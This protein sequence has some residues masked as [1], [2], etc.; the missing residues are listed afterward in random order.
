M[1][2]Q[3]HDSYMAAHVSEALAQDPRVGELGIRVEI[4]GGVVMVKGVVQT[5]ERREAIE[6]VIRELLPDKEIHNRVV[7]EDV[8]EAGEP[9]VLT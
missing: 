1:S 2:E 3:T 8:R 4:N 9:E 6:H 5:E 7:V